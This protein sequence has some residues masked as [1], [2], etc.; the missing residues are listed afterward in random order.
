MHSPPTV[1]NGGETPRSGARSLGRRPQWSCRHPHPSEDRRTVGRWIGDQEQRMPG[2]RPEDEAM[3]A[4]PDG[5]ARGDRGLTGGRRWSHLE[6]AAGA[7]LDRSA[8][9]VGFQHAHADDGTLVERKLHLHQMRHPGLCS[10]N[11][12]PLPGGFIGR[13]RRRQPQHRPERM[14]LDGGVASRQQAAQLGHDRRHRRQLGHRHIR[15]RH[16]RNRH[17]GHRHVGHAHAWQ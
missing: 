13:S 4:Q 12:D 16:I 2:G 11:H 14:H 6:S 17:I 3:P 10:G 8:R 7:D 1:G 5:L 9:R 15:N